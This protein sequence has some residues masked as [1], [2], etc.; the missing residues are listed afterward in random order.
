M[1]KLNEF[2][3]FIK[4][5]PSLIDKVHN[6]ELTWQKLYETYDIY[7]VNH[8]LF[9]VQTIKKP[10]TNLFT[11]DGVNNAMNVLKDIDLDKLSSGL[12]SLKK[13]V[14]TIQEITK[15][16][17]EASSKIPEYIKKNTFRRYND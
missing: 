3:E 9:K 11:K 6:K 1:S 2:K 7:G 15:P 12:D 5:Y 14:G 10:L 17:V 4:N 13:V 16:E 8:E